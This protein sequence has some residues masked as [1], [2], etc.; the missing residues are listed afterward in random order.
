MII[1]TLGSDPPPLER[2]KNIFYFLDTRPSILI[3][4]LFICLHVCHNFQYNLSN[5]AHLDILSV[6]NTSKG[7]LSVSNTSKDILSVINTSKDILSVSNTYLLQMAQL[8][9]YPN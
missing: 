4:L 2:D 7:N 6:S 8:F 9:Q 5:F 1:I 3:K